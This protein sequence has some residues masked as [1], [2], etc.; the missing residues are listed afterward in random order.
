MA[1]FMEAVSYSRA[2]NNTDLSAYQINKIARFS[3]GT[4]I[5]RQFIKP[6]NTINPNGVDIVFWLN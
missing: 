4:S 6:T 1:S 2:D 5:Y 3:F